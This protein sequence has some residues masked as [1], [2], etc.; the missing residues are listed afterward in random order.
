M[1]QFVFDSP[2]VGTPGQPA[3]RVGPADS[4]L[5]PARAQVSNVDVGGTTDGTYTV[6]VTLPDGRYYDASFVAVSQSAAQIAAG[7]VAAVL[8]TSALNGVVT[9]A[10]VTTDNVLLTFRELGVTYGISFPSNPGT[11][12]TKTTVTD[13]AVALLSLGIGAVRESDGTVRAPTTGDTG[14]DIHGF[15]VR[16]DAEILPRYAIEQGNGFRAGSAVPLATQ[17]DYWC[18]VEAAVAFMG[19]VFCRV[20]AGAGEVAGAL[21]GDS[22]GGDAVPI[23]AVFLRATTGAARTIVRLLG[24]PYVP[25]G[26]IT[27]DQLDFFASA[28]VTGTG[29]AQDVAHGLGRT[30]ALVWTSIVEF[31][32][33]ADIAYGVHDATN[34]KFTAT[35]GIKFRA[36]A[37]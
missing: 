25:P 36:F 31:T 27:G 15:V 37:L 33:A 34:L 2:T 6:R 1:P 16:S 9:A 28:E 17:G 8:A 5:Y 19:Q 3:G 20:V 10:V 30:P 12:L 22:D 13:P 11:N 26:G 32:A 35:S 29:S 7:L 21:R 24:L 18:D 14:A 4:A 23:N